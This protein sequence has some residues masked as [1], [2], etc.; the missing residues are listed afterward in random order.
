MRSTTVER[1]EKLIYFAIYINILYRSTAVERRRIFYWRLLASIYVVLTSH[2]GSFFKRF[3][4]LS[5]AILVVYD[6][7]LGCIMIAIKCSFAYY[8]IYFCFLSNVNMIA[9]KCN[10]IYSLLYIRLFIFIVLFV[11]SL[12]VCQ[13]FVFIFYIVL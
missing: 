1:S 5:Q 10:L 6:I 9:V 12:Q 2:L 3:N 7:S 13:L 8:Q 11:F 4:S